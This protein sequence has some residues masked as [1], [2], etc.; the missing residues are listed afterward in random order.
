VTPT[1]ARLSLV[2]ATA[3]WGLTF[4]A[5]HEL[6]KVLPPTHI[7]VLRFLVVSAVLGA[8]LAARSELRPRFSGREWALMLVCGLLSVPGAQLALTYG[9]RFLSPAMSGLVVATGPAF[10]AALAV[11]LLRERLGLRKWSGIALASVGAAVVVL[12]TTGT[13][14]DLTVRNPAGAALVVVAQLCWAGYTVLSKRL[15]A[16]HAPVTTVSVAVLVGTVAMAPFA[17]AALR[18]GADLGGSELLWLLHLVVF[19]TVVPYLIWFNALRH[20]PANET[21][22]FMFLVPL[23][24]VGWSAVLLGERP[25]ILGI[26]GGLTIVAGVAVTQAPARWSRTR[27][28]DRQPVPEVQAP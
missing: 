19:G 10:T 1:L 22:V 8:V 27:E 24:A 18:A 17:P 3:S 28:A 15:V 12:F 7:T 23:F 16:R 9:Q 20:L 25:A 2:G 13:G 5:N 21:A 26:V 14:T 11:V 6:L 4:T